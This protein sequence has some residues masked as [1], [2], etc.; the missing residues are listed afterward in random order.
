MC[1]PC[2]CQCAPPDRILSDVRAELDDRDP[3]VGVGVLGLR[4]LLF[5]AA[6][7]LGAALRRRPSRTCPLRLAHSRR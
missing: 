3:C 1:V 4:R 2:V 5:L 6:R 7:L